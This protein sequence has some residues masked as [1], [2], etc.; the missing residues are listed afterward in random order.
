VTLYRVTSRHPSNGEG[1]ICTVDTD[2]P[3][4]AEAYYRLAAGGVPSSWIV[5]VDQMVSVQMPVTVWLALATAAQTTGGLPLS[6]DITEIPGPEPSV[7]QD[8]LPQ[9]AVRQIEGEP[10]PHNT[11]IV[12][13]HVLNEIPGH[14]NDHP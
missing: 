2:T 8:Q 12:P 7:R 4:K 1:E 14:E 5:T 10:E 3:E 9:F 6:E 13:P 11:G